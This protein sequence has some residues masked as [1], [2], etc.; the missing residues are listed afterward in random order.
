[1]GALTGSVL[2]AKYFY[3]FTIGREAKREKNYLS[4]KTYKKMEFDSYNMQQVLAFPCF[5]D[6]CL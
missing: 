3:S 5:K 2:Y 1:M 6:T 4:R